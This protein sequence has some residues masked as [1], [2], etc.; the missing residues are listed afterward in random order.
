MRELSSIC[1]SKKSIDNGEKKDK[2]R[3]GCISILYR[4]MEMMPG[5]LAEIEYL[6]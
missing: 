5:E 2:A 6:P 1:Q 3:N 4:N